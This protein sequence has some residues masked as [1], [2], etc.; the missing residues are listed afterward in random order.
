MRVDSVKYLISGF[1]CLIFL[2]SVGLSAAQK[3]G[4][5]VSPEE[6]TVNLG[7]AAIFEVK[8]ENKMM[9]TDDF[10]F[11][12]TGRPSHWINLDT[13]YLIL[14]PLVTEDVKIEFYPNDEPGV[15]D[16]DVFFQSADE[17]DIVVS[18]RIR[19]RVLYEGRKIEVLDHEIWR[20][21][22]SIKM[23]VDIFSNI[24]DEVTMDFSLSGSS[25][26]TIATATRTFTVQGEE[27]IT[28]TLTIP[29][30]IVAD[31]YVAKIVVK[32]TEEEF[33]S[34]FDIEPVSK[35]VKTDSEIDTLFF[36][37]SRIT[38]SNE[39]NVIEEDYKV[40]SDIPTGLVT[41]FKQPE[42]CEDNECEWIIGK[43]NPDESLQIIYR[44]EYW[45]LFL[46]GMVISVLLVS[47]FVFAWK[48]ANTP[49]LK[50]EIEKKG[51][52]AYTAVIEIKNPGKKITN[53]V[54]RDHVSP[55]FKVGREFESVKPA[56]RETEEGT[57]LVWSIAS[58]E[59]KDHRMLHYSIK[60]LVSGQLKMTKAYMRYVTA[61]G[62][63]SKVESKEKGLS[64]A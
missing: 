2:A 25:G 3:I 35:M 58:I 45:P 36:H 46:Q 23:R 34:S 37:E 32:E 31:T 53:V 61:K 60:P 44:L 62:K 4:M 56:I 52:G 22:D 28:H 64:A 41:F 55:L 11:F 54:I 1:V 15:Y 12:V 47:F 29:S 26:K 42:K 49:V 30:D 8:L 57:E 50:K 48:R 39:G 16:Y 10:Y 27:T 24:E 13:S 59:P 63:R 6:R 5:E 38:L 9:R 19:L 7:K 40:V 14:P 51:E 20:E 18:K 17:P 33:Q 43:L 21:G